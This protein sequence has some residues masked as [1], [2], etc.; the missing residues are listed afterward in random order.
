MNQ[1]KIIG[2]LLLFMII[3]EQSI[4][5]S[6]PTD[7]SYANDKLN[8]KASRVI[9]PSPDAAA[10]GQYGNVQV[11]LFTGTPKIGVP[12][13]EIGGKNVNLSIDMSYNASGFKP[14]DIASWVG[15]GWTLNAG[16]VITRSVMG[17]PDNSSNYFYANNAYANTSRLTNLY[18]TYN[19]IDSIQKGY[20]E[21]QPDVYYFNFGSYSGKFFVTPDLQIIKKEKNN[22]NISAQGINYIDAS[23][24]SFTIVDEKGNTYLFAAA[25]MS[26]MQLDDGLASNQSIILSY[27]YPSSWY[28]SSIT[29]ADGN[30]RMVFNYSSVASGQTMMNNYLQNNS[31][32]Y[33]HNTRVTS[34]FTYETFV[35]NNIFPPP[36]VTITGKKYLQSVVFY[37][38]PQAY[39]TVNFETVTNQRQDL[40]HTQ[41]PGEQL[42]QDIKIYNQSGIIKQ[43]NFSYSY[44]NNS[45]YPTN[46][47]NKRLRLDNIQE[48]AVDGVTANKPPYTFSYNNNPIPTYTLAGLDHW[49]FYNNTDNISTLVPNYS[50]PGDITQYG[51]GANREPDINGSSTAIL[52]QIT[53]PT[54]GYT[55]FQYELHQGIDSHDGVTLHNVGGLRVKSITDYS[56]TSK[57]ATTKSYSYLTNSGTSSGLTTMPNYASFSSSHHYADGTSPDYDIYYMTLSANSVF[58][59]GTIQG[60]HIGYAQVTETQTDPATNNSLGK[61]VYRYN[62]LAPNQNDDNI[63]NGELIEQTVYDINNKVLSDL[64]NTYKD[65]VVN[66]NAVVI[67]VQTLNKQ[68]NLTTLCLP[69]N[70]GPCIWYNPATVGFAYPNTSC[71][72]TK[73]FNTKY[74]YYGYSMLGQSKNLVQQTETKYDQLTSAYTTVTKKFTYGNPNHTYPTL[75]E[76]TASNNDEI[77]TSI[78]YAGDYNTA[79]ATDNNSLGIAFLQSKNIIGADIETVQYRQNL[80]G[81]NKRYIGGKIN[82]YAPNYPYLQ[83]MYHLEMSQPLL[84]VQAS[85]ISGGNFTFDPNYKPTAVFAY[86]AY[87]NLSQQGK[88]MDAPKSYVWDYQHMLPSA[89]VNNAN[90]S[91]IAYTGFEPGATGG[92][93]SGFNPSSITTGAIAGQNSYA[94]AG[95]SLSVINLS[96]A[97]QYIVSYWIHSGSV[98]V[99]TNTGSATGVPGTSINGWTYYEHLLPASSTQVTVSSGSAN[100]DELRLFPKDAQMSTYTYN[101]LV[102]ITSQC[103]PDNKFAFYEYDGLTRLVNVKDQYGNIIKNY[104]Y[105]YGLGAAL[106]ASPQT[107]FYSSSQQGTFTAA[108]TCAT[109]SYP[110]TI[111]YIVPFAKYVSSISQADA[112]N[113]AIADLNQNGQAYANSLPCLY[114]NVAISVR[115]FK[116]DCSATQGSGS[117]VMYTV[118]A[119]K[120][121]ST[122]SQTDANNQASA[123]AAANGQAYANA[124]GTCSCGLEG[125]KIVNGVCETGTR[126]NSSSTVQPNGSW[127]CT[128]YYGFSDGS[129]SQ[130]YSVT[131][132]SP[133]P[134]Q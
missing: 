112:N 3:I 37:K 103:T 82:F 76:Q 104:K 1:K 85:G 131:G 52:Q 132:T 41:F 67:K 121:S 107:L 120:Y 47:Y 125:Q 69:S 44:F 111:T 62:I 59:L 51:S 75:I 35:S 126:Y 86:D 94:L 109:G 130:F 2:L 23:S 13:Y 66:A 134:I 28:L 38:G 45:T 27:N 17:N 34:N 53:Y 43:Y 29:S 63:S 102:G 11:S 48:I 105:N 33:D 91:D 113:K 133:C 56:F 90:S 114:Y 99:S 100:I 30:E 87:G 32:T 14:Q 95:G 58:G 55:T 81:S 83:S 64:Q 57:Q 42:L 106:N 73:I 127:L 115:F 118:P 96:A 36:T 24:S 80:D 98:S 12:L 7:Y 108:V 22:L 74:N 18:S 122:I 21:T 71:S 60:S 31:V 93:W 124:N 129:V 15:L 110:Q 101:P 128:Y 68:D 4:G 79:G 89:E 39:T 50:I 40:D 116:N 123:D 119:G 26:F 72:L 54:G 78:K 46:Y 20:N 49:G 65:T 77:A 10:L 70:G 61:T 97:K 19:Y 8:F 5:Q 16:G 92:N 88:Y 9:P 84:T 6:S 25:E 117:R